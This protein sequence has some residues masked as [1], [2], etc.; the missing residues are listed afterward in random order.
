M[1]TMSLNAL[2]QAVLDG[3]TEDVRQLAESE[4]QLLFQPTDAGTPILALA[5]QRGVDLGSVVALIRAGAPGADAP[6]DWAELLSH[7][8]AELSESCS[9]AGWLHGLEFLLWHRVATRAHLPE[10]LDDLGSFSAL[11]VGCLSDLEFLARRAGGW[12]TRTSDDRSEF[13]AMDAWKLRYEHWV[14]EHVDDL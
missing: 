9:C 7:Y 12:W 8:M 10:A 11:S 3:R 13:L 2:Q 4:R 1:G 6:R 5:L 14:A